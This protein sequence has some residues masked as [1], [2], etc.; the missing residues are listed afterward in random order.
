LQNP[1][2]AAAAGAGMPAL[3]QAAAAQQCGAG[4]DEMFRWSALMSI[5]IV[6]MGMAIAALIEYFL[7]LFL[8]MLVPDFNHCTR[9]RNGKF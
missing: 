9:R 4:R 5:I 2:A 8:E 7:Y 6:V 3:A 1:N